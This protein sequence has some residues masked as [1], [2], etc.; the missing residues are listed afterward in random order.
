MNGRTQYMSSNLP[1]IRKPQWSAI[2]H[3][4]HSYR[5]EGNYGFN[6]YTIAVGRSE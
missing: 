6:N 2:I 4:Y 5:K 1:C 3:Q